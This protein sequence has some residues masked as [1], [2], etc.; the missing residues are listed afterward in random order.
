MTR[1]FITVI[2]SIYLFSMLSTSTNLKETS[3]GFNKTE[4]SYIDLQS[5]SWIPEIAAYS[6]IFDGRCITVSV[7]PGYE[8][9]T[10][11]SYTYEISP[12]SNM[13]SPI[14]GS[15]NSTVGTELQFSHKGLTL[16][17]VY[18]MRARAND[19]FTNAWSP[20]ETFTTRANI[21][22]GWECM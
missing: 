15:G 17:T 6:G 18:Y 20:I 11:K 3:S 10:T 9:N 2:A 8:N 16:N 7:S 1:I 14:T 12:N 22:P 13:S 21:T 4:I 5:V 19:G